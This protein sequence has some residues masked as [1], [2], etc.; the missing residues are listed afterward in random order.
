METQKTK[1]LYSNQ[2]FEEYG[3]E[4]DDA[5]ELLNS[6]ASSVEGT[7]SEVCSAPDFYLKQACSDVEVL[8]P[9]T[10][11]RCDPQFIQPV[12]TL[13]QSNLPSPKD[14]ALETISGL[15]DE[16]FLRESNWL[17]GKDL[18]HN[19]YDFTLVHDP[20]LMKENPLVEKLVSYSHSSMKKV[21]EY[22]FN[23]A[24]KGFSKVDDF[25]FSYV[26]FLKDQIADKD[27]DSLMVEAMKPFKEKITKLKSNPNRL[28]LISQ[29][30]TTM[31][32]LTQK[33]LCTTG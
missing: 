28:T 27:A 13:K 5:T 23:M 1:T 26:D 3:L 29:R 33:M 6:L 25:H 7:E 4:F 14:L 30:R 22:I 32:S 8:D 9:R 16:V 31:S 18:M 21:F 20:E 19:F 11:I 15:Y 10:D 2:L 17:S 24:Q 12:D